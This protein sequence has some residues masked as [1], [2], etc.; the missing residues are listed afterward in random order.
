MRGIRVSLLPELGTVDAASRQTCIVL[1]VLRATTTIGYALAAGAQCI[2]PCLEVEQA[3]ATAASLGRAKVLLAGERGGLPIPGFDLGN[4]PQEFTRERV[5]GRTI[6]FTTTNGT[7]ALL[8][9]GEAATV[10]LGS[11]ANLSAV[12]RAATRA[13]H[14]HLVCAGT[15]GWVT[16][17]DVL[18][19]GAIVEQ[20]TRDGQLTRVGGV[21][22][23]VLLDDQAALARDAWR[24]VVGA[25]FDIGACG[26]SAPVNEP[27]AGAL[28]ES[29]GGQNLM[30]LG[31]ERDIL[32]AARIDCHD[33]VPWFDPRTQSIE[34]LSA[35][36]ARAL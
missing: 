18:A 4:S 11:F 16:R 35:A 27:I 17:E 9:C 20:L 6:V 2:R 30:A 21:G 12:C 33:L 23:D 22:G 36:A 14:L 7:R 26:E 10:L 13:E 28:R 29:R 5:A 24:G 25:G 3:V 8:L 15:D 1:D 19:A 31:L 32:V 34:P